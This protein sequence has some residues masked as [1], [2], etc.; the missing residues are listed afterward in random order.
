M[1]VNIYFRT[2]K[3]LKAKLIDNYLHITRVCIW[4]FKQTKLCSANLDR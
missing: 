1:Y 3:K 2:E 4:Q